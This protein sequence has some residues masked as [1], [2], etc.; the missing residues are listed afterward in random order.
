[1]VLIATSRLEASVLGAI[2]LAHAAG[3]QPLKNLVDSRSAYLAT[4]VDGAES[5]VSGGF[6]DLAGAAIGLPKTDCSPL[7]RFTLNS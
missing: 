5:G 4:S 6:M 2:N 1:M 7:R 3:A